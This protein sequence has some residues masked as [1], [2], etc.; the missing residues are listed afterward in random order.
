[1]TIF[2][3]THNLDEAE[4]LC[5]LVGVIRDGQVITVGHPDDLKVNSFAPS[6]TIVGSGF[7][8]EILTKLRQMPEV[9]SVDVMEDRLI[10]QLRGDGKSAALVN[11]IVKSGG[12]IEEVM[13]GKASL[14][15]VFLLLMQENST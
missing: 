15:E 4:K 1:M 11:L 3:T 13:K 14:E 9:I 7:S 10:I 12:E 8:G 5:D 6:V 2:L